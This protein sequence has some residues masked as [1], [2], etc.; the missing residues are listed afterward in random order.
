MLNQYFSLF[1]R[2]DLLLS[3]VIIM[4]ILILNAGSSSLKYQ[5]FDMEN[6]EV[7]CSGLVERIAIDGGKITHKTKTG[8]KHPFDLDLPNHEVALHKVL[9]ILVNPEY[10]AVKSLDEINA[11]GHRVVHGGEKFAHSTLIT[12]EVKKVLHELIELAPLH[13]P[14]NIM[15]IEACE[16]VLP[17][18]PNVAVF[19]TAFHQTMKPDHFL[20]P[21]PYEWYENH[22]VRRYGFHGTSHR[23]VSERLAEITG[24]NDLKIITCHVG[25]GA[26]IT[27]VDSGKVIETSM[28]LTPLEG[29][30]MGTRCGDIDPAIVPFMMKKENLTPDQIDTIMNKKSGVLG[31][32]QISSDHRD[33]E[34][35]YNEGKERE[36]TVT[37]MY[38]NAILKYIG[39]YVA[40]LQGVDAIVFTAGV[41]ENSMLQRR[42]IASQLG[43][44][45]AHFDESLN[46]FRGEEKAITTPDSKVQIW[47]I[48]TNEELMIAK[49]T[50]ELVK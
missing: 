30:M 11:V 6:N 15:G 34:G 31:V 7:L 39:S 33:I 50:Y 20:Y 46:N 25:N 40:L 41:L 1:L 45:G 4:K 44:L 24:R 12:P 29:L 42:L 49:D 32:S 27:A 23:Y 10:G 5:M 22:K 14:A 3:I 37:N 43:W 36:V 8:E 47:V 2:K 28:G 48:P 26:S 21:L 18:V 13:N 9:D 35:G 19:D 38:T 17:G 16:K